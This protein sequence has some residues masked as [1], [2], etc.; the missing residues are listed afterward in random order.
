MGATKT[1]SLFLN[2]YPV[3]IILSSLLA[4]LYPPAMAWF[5]GNFMVVGL[6]LVM[7]GMGF[8]L[9]IDDFKQLLKMPGSVLLGFIIMYSV[10]P[11]SAWTIAKLLN[12]EPGLAVGLILLGC[13]PGGTASNIIAFIARAN[14]ALSV[15]LTTASTLGGIIVKPLV[16]QA[17][18]GQYIPIEPWGIFITMIKMILIPVAIGVYCNYK[19]PKSVG[20]ISVYGPYV[21][22]I[23]I[24]FI[25]GGIVAQSAHA[26]A[27]Y[28]GKLFLAAFLLHILGFLLGYF[29]TRLFKYDERTSRTISIETGMQNGGLAAVL[30]KTNFP[31]QPLVAVP[32]IF[33]SVI[34]TLAGGIIAAY[35]RTKKIEDT[36]TEK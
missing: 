30:A 32:A 2:L 3:W 31:L 26:I 8:T 27:E 28:A 19:F 34:Q 25:A 1:E 7:L 23:A 12:L 29:T 24:I 36:D 5:T 13:C 16:F 15:I 6:S 17:L 33:S 20:K 11:L 18:A 14:V 10:M 21:S 4:F 22:V 9:K 35:W